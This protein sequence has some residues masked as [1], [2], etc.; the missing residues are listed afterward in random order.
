MIEVWYWNGLQMLQRAMRSRSKRRYS[1]SR[2]SGKKRPFRLA[3]RQYRARK[4]AENLF[5]CFNRAI[6]LIALRDVVEHV[7]MA[8]L[9]FR[10]GL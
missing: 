4:R 7:E 10:S 8:R 9:A 1:R 2:S 5:P 6:G 3:R